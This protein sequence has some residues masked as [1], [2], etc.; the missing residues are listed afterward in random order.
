MQRRDANIEAVNHALIAIEQGNLKEALSFFEDEA[1]WRRAAVLPGGG[2]FEGHASIEALLHGIRERLGGR[3]HL[4]GLTLYGAGEH[5]FA[6]YTVS[7]SEDA[8]ADGAEHVLTAFD[9]VLGKIRE[10]R[11]FAFRVR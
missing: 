1:M 3:L 2:T 5:V 10:V 8:Y 9:V 11:E 7:P 4:L 6:D